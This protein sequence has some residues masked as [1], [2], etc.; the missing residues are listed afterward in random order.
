MSEL[1]QQRIAARAKARPDAVAVV[2][3][4]TRMTY[5]AL[6]EA[7]NRLGRLLLDA[8]CRRGDRVALLMP[9]LPAAIVAMLAVLK[10]DAAYVPLDPAGPAAR[11]A[12]ML[13]ASDCR[14]ILVAGSTGPPLRPT[15]AGPALASRPRGGWLDRLAPRRAEV[16]PCPSQP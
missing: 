7:S 6:D 13:E 10:A 5:R 8:G 11:L 1:L 12:R 4:D 15:L 16:H 3:A 2:Y 14:C 9:K